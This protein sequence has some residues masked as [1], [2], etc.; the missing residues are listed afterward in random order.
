MTP[1]LINALHA[2]ETLAA[3]HRRLADISTGA[4]REYHLDAAERSLV[5]IEN[6]RRQIAADGGVTP[7]KQAT[8]LHQRD[9]ATAQALIARH[10][11]PEW[12]VSEQ[13]PRL[14]GSLVQD[15][16]DAIGAARAD[17]G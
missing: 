16:A 8:A 2:A 11:L 9:V 1:T 14:L 10:V 12:L 3:H 4:T 5:E 13:A 6:I 17:G 7:E 15:I